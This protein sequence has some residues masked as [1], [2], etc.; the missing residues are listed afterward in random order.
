MISASLSGAGHDD[1]TR[2]EIREHINSAL[3]LD[4]NNG[5]VLHLVVVASVMVSDGETCLRLARRLVDMRPASA[6]SY[7]ALATA[8]LALGRIDAAMEALNTQLRCKGFDSSRSIALYLLGWCYLLEGRLEESLDALIQGLA[9]NP[10]AVLLLRLK[11]MTEASLGNERE[12]LA[13]VRQTKE[14][15]PGM[16]LDT[17]LNQF[18]SNP[19][20]AKRMGEHLAAF[21][22]LW[23][24][25]EG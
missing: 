20:L 18:I 7:H 9:Y 11:A 14:I 10:H 12:A 16:T 22:R 19:R 2:R 13:T 6:R 25:T 15:E 5:V 23:E 8:C 3:Q 24:E 17:H 4:G 1:A 21:H